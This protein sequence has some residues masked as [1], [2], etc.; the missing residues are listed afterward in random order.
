MSI[1]A[2]LIFSSI[3]LFSVFTMHLVRVSHLQKTINS[4]DV[5][6]ALMMTTLVPVFFYGIFIWAILSVFWISKKQPT[7]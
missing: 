3:A 5:T 4:I 1:F 6:L 7:R 2:G